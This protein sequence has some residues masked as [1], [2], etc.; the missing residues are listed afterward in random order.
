MLSEGLAEEKRPE[1]R[2]SH[3]VI[4]DLRTGEIDE[5]RLPKGIRS[6]DLKHMSELVAKHHDT[7][8]GYWESFHGTKVV[9]EVAPCTLEGQ[10]QLDPK[11]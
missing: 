5:G 1:D 3:G 7:L 6:K 2:G 10:E 4:I 9:R 11:Q 8:A